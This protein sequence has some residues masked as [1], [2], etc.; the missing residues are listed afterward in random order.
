MSDSEELAPPEDKKALVERRREERLSRIRDLEDDILER[1]CRVVDAGMAWGEVEF[2][3][4]EPPREWVEQYGEKAA[5]DR[6]NIAKAAWMPQ[7]QAPVGL[8]LAA[9][10]LVGIAKARGLRVAQ[11]N[12]QLNV[13]ICLPPPTSKAHPDEAEQ[14]EVIDV[15]P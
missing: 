8:K 2:N 14:Y 12:N 13:Q 7:S 10:V 11:T 5:R 9:Q 1:S 4:P 6:L 15:D 3:Q